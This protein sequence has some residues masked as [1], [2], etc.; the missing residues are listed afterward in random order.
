MAKWPGFIGGYGASQSL[1]GSG[2]KTVNMYVERLPQDGANAAA[3]LSVPGQ[4][5]WGSVSQVGTRGLASLA[6]SQ[7]FSVTGAKLYEF[8]ANATA[9]DR[10]TL[11]ID[12][13]PAQ[14]A[15]NGVVG[16]QIGIA[17]GGNIYCYDLTSHVLSGPHL[18][19]GYTHIGYAGGFGLAFN[20]TT[21]KVNLSN[22]N[23]MTVWNAGTFFQRSLFSDPWRAMFVDQNNLVWLIGTDSYEVWQNTGQGT[24]P[25]APLS[26]LVGVVGIAAPFAYSSGRDGNAWISRNQEGQGELVT[27]HG[28]SP[29]AVST[30]AVNNAVNAILRQRTIDNAEIL[31]YQDGGHRFINVTFPSDA[32]YTFDASE[33]LWAQRGKWQPNAGTYAPWTPRCHAMAFGKHLVGDRTTGT[34]SEMD[35]TFCT[36]LDGVGIRRLRQ[37]PVLVRELRRV[38]LDQLELLM[39]VG[40]GIQL[41]QGA[42]PQIMLR[43]SDDAGR[44]FGNEMIASV[45]R[46]GEFSRRVYWTRLGDVHNAAVEFS[47]SDPIPFRVVD[48]FVNNLEEL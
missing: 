6:N 11:A 31:T 20:G 27:S 36:E 12:S 9:T 34:I 23:N 8:D 15:Y 46:V 42:D 45:G 16:G 19:S 43:V 30:Y 7:L 47:F 2:S 44:T 48:C 39:D 40:E 26:G 21:G 38:P 4:R 41:G 35:S 25:W 29:E 17:A 14:M 32:T 10:G 1:Q 33:T 3:L 13:N 24:Q 22:L 28:S 5:R 18:G 37:A